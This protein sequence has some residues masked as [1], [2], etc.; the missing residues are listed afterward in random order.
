M[1]G[2]FV[3]VTRSKISKKND[4]CKFFKMTKLLVKHTVHV[5]ISKN[6]YA[7]FTVLVFKAQVGQN[8]QKGKL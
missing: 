1:V 5:F 2:S 7:I 3:G 4:T 6:I 8:G